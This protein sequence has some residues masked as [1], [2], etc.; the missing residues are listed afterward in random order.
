MEAYCFKC[1]GKHELKDPRPIFFANG[2]PATQ[3][4][5][6][7][8]GSEKVFKM[9]RTEAHEGMEKPIPVTPAGADKRAGTWW[10]GLTGMASSAFLAFANLDTTG[11]LLI[12]GVAVLAFAFF[13]WRGEIIVRRIKTLVAEIGRG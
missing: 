4:T 2:S 12:G 3:G 6:S 11:K 13:I 1:R 7:N 9:G 8:C 10:T 5:C